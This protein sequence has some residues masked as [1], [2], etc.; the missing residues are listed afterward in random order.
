MPADCRPTTSPSASPWYDGGWIGAVCANP[1]D[2]TSSLVLRPIGE[3]RRAVVEV[4]CASRQLYKLPRQS[5]ALRNK[6]VSFMTP[7]ALA[8]DDD[9]PSRLFSGA[10]AIQGE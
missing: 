9:P 4:R 8:E 7:V 2:N 5:P 1:H 10:Y 6:R 3:G